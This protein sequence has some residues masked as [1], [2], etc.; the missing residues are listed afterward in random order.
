M[1]AAWL[2]VFLVACSGSSAQVREARE[3]KYDV[4]SSVVFEA[5]MDVAEDQ[6]GIAEFDEQA[7]ALATEARWY[8]AEG[9]HAGRGTED[10]PA[11]MSKDMVML[12]FVIRVTG[13][14]HAWTITVEP[15]ANRL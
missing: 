5:A 1:R 7:Q 3:A 12:E 4:E 13:D 14:V 11:Q 2:L 8:T 9:S 15:V 10:H 6:Y